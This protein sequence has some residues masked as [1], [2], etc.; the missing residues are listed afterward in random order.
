MKDENIPFP[1]WRIETDGIRRGLLQRLAQTPPRACGANVIWS[2]EVV[3]IDPLAR[4]IESLGSQITAN[5]GLKF[6][7]IQDSIYT[8]Q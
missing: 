4:K 8:D 7:N 1:Y 6:V 2:I 3:D 5:G